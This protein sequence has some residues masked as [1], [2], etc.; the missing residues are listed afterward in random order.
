MTTI[1]KWH[2]PDIQQLNGQQPEFFPSFHLWGHTF[3]P[4]RVE[5]Q[6]GFRSFA[7]SN[8]PG[9]PNVA[10]PF[11]GHPHHHPYGSAIIRPPET[12]HAQERLWWMDQQILARYTRKFRKEHGIVEEIMY[13]TAHFRYGQECSMI[14]PGWFLQSLGEIPLVIS[15]IKPDDRPDS[16][17]V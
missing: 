4:K 9:Q 1:P 12:V 6:T 14:L 11:R 15:C 17:A 7:E 5:E 13:V 2:E 3:S 16:F 10:G 8:E